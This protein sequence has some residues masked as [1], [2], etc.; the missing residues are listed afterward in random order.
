MIRRALTPSELPLSRRALREAVTHGHLLR[1]RRGRYLPASAHPDIVAAARLGCRLDCVSLLRSLGVFVLDHAALHV[2]AA[3]GS[4]R[5][6]LPGDRVVRHWRACAEAAGTV[7]VDLVDALAQSC[8]CQ[9]P[10]SAI[11]TL[12]SALHLGLID[13]DGLTEVFRRLPA[14]FAHL[15]RLLD[16]RAESGAETLMR[17]LL[18]T[19]PCSVQVQVR[20]NG[21]GRVDFVVD[22]WLIIECDSRAHHEGWDAQRNDRRRDLTAATLGYTTIRPMAEDIFFRRDELRET[23]AAILRH[24]PV[25]DR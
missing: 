2:H 10:R 9:D 13:E 19:L 17:L 4:S 5:L 23:I 21:V 6:P 20:V 3:N 15:R 14:R 25:A 18:R 24:R 1:V 7:V 22:G 16:P 11:A 8:R 12:D